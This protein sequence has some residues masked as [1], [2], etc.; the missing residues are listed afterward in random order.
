MIL[1]TIEAI[2]KAWGPRVNDKVK[3]C[4]KFVFELRDEHG[5]LKQ[6]IEKHNLITTVGFQFV[7]DAMFLSA[8]RPAIMGYI[9]L[10]SGSSAAAA[11][12][13]ALQTQLMCKAFTY[14]Y[15]GNVVTASV[16]FNPGEAT[17]NIQEA[18]LFNAASAGTMLN[19]VVLPS[20]FPKASGDTLTS[21]FTITLS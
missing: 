20:A 17:G 18:A 1:R 8:S 15:T 4:G 13:T 19:R 2:R 12:N 11:G 9:G 14:S 3:L 7:A 10:G 5:N 16:T 6:R 21:T